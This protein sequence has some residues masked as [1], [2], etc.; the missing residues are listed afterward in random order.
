MARRRL[1]MFE[2]SWFAKLS[3]VAPSYLFQSVLKLNKGRRPQVQ[4][5]PNRM[6]VGVKIVIDAIKHYTTTSSDRSKHRRS[7]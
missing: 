3:S 6:S 7:G 4:Q 1:A 2:G 5:D